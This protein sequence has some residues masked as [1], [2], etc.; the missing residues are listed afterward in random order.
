[1]PD[2]F[3]QSQIE[4]ITNALGDT[5]EGLTG[6]EIAYLLQLAEIP[7]VSPE[8]A[9]RFRLFNSFAQSQ[10]T[11]QHRRNILAFIRFAMKPARFAR[12]FE[13]FEVLRTHLN[14]A[15]AFS[16]LS[17][18]TKGELL[19][20]EKAHTLPEAQRR[21]QELRSNLTLREVHPD[22]LTFCREELLADDYFHA[23]LEATKSIADKLRRLTGTNE[24]GAALVDLSFGGNLPRF[25]INALANESEKSEQRGFCNLVKGL[26]G[27]FRNPT[28]HEARINWPMQRADAEDL[29]SVVSLIHRRIDGAYRR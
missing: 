25:A 6:T 5:S 29:L 27:M 16:G 14:H 7:D 8:L 23:V 9:K 17:V 22:V 15:L 19:R 28:A 4:A 21:A 12:N 3:D 11:N 10:N 1:M 2:L 20:V 18:D 13:R 26:F 24:D